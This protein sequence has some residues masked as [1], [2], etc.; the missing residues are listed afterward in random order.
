MATFKIRR[1]VIFDERFL[2]FDLFGW[3][4]RV[5]SRAGHKRP[6]KPYYDRKLNGLFLFGGLCIGVMVWTPKPNDEGTGCNGH[7]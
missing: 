3:E 5:F 6:W 1:D 2:E 7:A 4:G